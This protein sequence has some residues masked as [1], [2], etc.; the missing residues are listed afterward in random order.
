MNSADVLIES[1][2]QLVTKKRHLKQGAMQELLTGKKRLPGFTE[3]WKVKRLKEIVHVKTG[4]RNNED[5]IDNGTYPFF[6]R[7]PNVER[8]NTYSH[9]CAA[10]LVPGEGNI[11]N[12]FHYINGRF[13]VHQRVYAITQFSPEVSG[14]YVYFYRATMRFCVARSGWPMVIAV[15]SSR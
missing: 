13:D 2:E 3:E 7:S 11:G 1:L 10:I 8:I 12:I 5:K 15:E 4:G 6:V 14:R 9:D